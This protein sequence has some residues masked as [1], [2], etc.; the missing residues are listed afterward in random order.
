MRTSFEAR[1]L[2]ADP[3]GS[4]ISIGVFDGVHL[5]HQ[6][7]LRANVARAREIGAEATVVTFRRHP[8]K[9]LLGR[10]PG[11]LT[12]LDHRLELFARLGVEHT[13]A[14][15]FDTELRELS[16]EEFVR[17][18]LVRALGARHFVLG[19][20]SKF[21][22][23]RRGG[24][25]LLQTLGYP[26]DV[27]G[28]V[29]VDRRPVSSTAIREAVALGDLNGAQRMLGRPLSV[30]GRVVHG[31][32]LGRRI[33]FP[34]ANL[35]LMQGLHPPA[36][37]YAVWARVLEGEEGRRFGAALPAVANI[38]RRPTVAGESAEERVEVHLLDFAG[39]L[40][41]RR[42]EVEF[43]AHLRGER[44]FSGIE[45]LSHQ[46]RRDVAAARAV[47]ELPGPHS[48]QASPSIGAPPVDAHPSD[49]ENP[50]PPAR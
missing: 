5:G 49:R 7:I 27:V 11:A 23:D 48:G 6:A 18:W 14:L 46:I 36:G 8:K 41:G 34:T 16:A 37:V 21:G 3:R 47:L 13:V 50:R 30:L 43:A 26:L 19:F 44:R 29:L 10:A 28:Q 45:A 20:D 42:L 1:K 9:V 12:T 35:N 31:E 15:N 39:D 38:G 40:Y 24:P 22:R 2:E 4:T 32:A 25:E 17:E 33:G